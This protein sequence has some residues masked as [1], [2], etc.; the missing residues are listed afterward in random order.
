MPMVRPRF[1]SW[2]RS[3]VGARKA[4]EARRDAPE[5]EPPHPLLLVLATIVGAGLQCLLSGRRRRSFS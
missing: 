4:E 2:N 5:G 1:V 3:L